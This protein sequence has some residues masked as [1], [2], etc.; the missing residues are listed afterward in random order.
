MATRGYFKWRLSSYGEGLTR[1][2]LLA[3]AFAR[4]LPA[5]KAEVSA[6]DLSLLDDAAVPNELFFVREHFPQPADLSSAAWKL[7]VAGKQLSFDEVVARPKRNI[8]FTLECAENPVGGGLVSH[9]EWTG[10]PLASLL[11]SNLPATPEARFVTLS[12]ADGFSRTIPIEKA[13]HPDTLIV[14]A[15][16]GEKL[17][18]S[19]GFPLRAIVPGWYGMDSVKWLR[20]IDAVSGAAP[21]DGYIRKVKSL[22]SGVRDA[23]RVTGIQ[24][25]SVFTRPQDGAILSSRRFVARGVAWA[26]ENL[27]SKV[28][29]SLDGGKSWMP[30]KIDDSPLPYSWARWSFDWKIPRSGEYTLTVR[31]TDVKGRVQPGEREPDRADGYESNSW[32]TIKVMAA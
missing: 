2:V 15:M 12:A 3:S 32:Q 22:L 28:E 5:R 13:L 29:M 26:G 10:V 25:K 17:P 14:Y 19:H 4:V 30:A 6:F 9:A 8:L 18:L 31:A 1:R 16:N 20:G 21:A 23:G 24:V 7:S 27:V 11:P